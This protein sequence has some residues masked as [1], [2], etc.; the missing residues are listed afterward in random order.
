MPDRLCIV[1]PTGY[2]LE[3]A[4]MG[5]WL[6]HFGYTLARHTPELQEIFQFNISNHRVPMCRNA[7]VTYALRRNC[8]HMLWLDPDMAVDRYVKWG[9]GG[10]PIDGTKAFW[11]EAWP[12]I[13]QHPGSIT[14]APYCG[15]APGQPVHVFVKTQDGK[16]V[17]VSHGTAQAQQ[18]W[19]SVEAVGAGV[20]LM[21]TSIFRRLKPDYF[22]DT[23]TNQYRDEL[24]HSSD[25]QFSLRCR[26]AGIPIYVCWD[27]WAG[28]WQNRCVEK[29]G[30]DPQPPP[31][32]PEPL[33]PDPSIP[34]LQE[35]HPNA[36]GAPRI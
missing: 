28:H 16:L 9:P 27:T 12:F 8:T 5:T 14:A 35:Q 17:R 6:F 18:G 21:D 7:C 32:A 20:M 25:V 19:T 29:P 31:P 2:N 26:A 15:G 23:F 34:V 3:A 4:D 22:S 11:L 24:R 1:R 33:S 36:Q 10:T 13:K 30:F